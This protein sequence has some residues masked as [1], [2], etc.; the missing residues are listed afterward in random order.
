MYEPL[1][2]GAALY[3]TGKNDYNS[4]A[5]N[6]LKRHASEMPRRANRSM[7]QVRTGAAAGNPL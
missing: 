5:N 1:N 7:V 4:K 6:V 3:K 2:R